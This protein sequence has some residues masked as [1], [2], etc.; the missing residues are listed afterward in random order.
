[1]IYTVEITEKA[2]DDLAE[3]IKYVS[4]VLDAPVAAKKLYNDI[5]ECIYSLSQMP[6]R[7]KEYDS[8]KYESYNLR[9]VSV[10]NYCV[11]YTVDN[12]KRIVYIVSI[13]FGR[14]DL[15]K[16]IAIEH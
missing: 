8:E 16:H 12:N 11:F 9:M 5:K 2:Q 7:Y 13:L 14:M 15:E 10:N 6:E 1:M 4:S 3:I